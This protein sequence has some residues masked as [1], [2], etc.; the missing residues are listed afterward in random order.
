V[1]FVLAMGLFSVVEQVVTID[2]VF[3]EGVCF[4]GLIV[5]IALLLML[6][7]RRRLREFGFRIGRSTWID[8]L[9]GVGLGGLSGALATAAIF[10]S[11]AQ[12]MAFLQ[13]QAFWQVMVGIWLVSSI[14]EEILCRGLIQTW[15]TTGGTFRIAR[16]ALSERVIASGLLFGAMHLSIIFHGADALTVCFI[17]AFTTSLGLITAYYRDKT[18]SLLLPVVIHIAGNVGA[19]VG[20][21]ITAILIFLVTGTPPTAGT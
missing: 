4:K 12:G 10:L 6:A 3:L 19:L 14:A 9:I 5:V 7:D 16:L 17:I 15:M 20:G 13:D 11:P 21:L 2:D 18:D 8:W 1:L